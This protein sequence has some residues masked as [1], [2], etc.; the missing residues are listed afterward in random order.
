MTGPGS[1][2][3]PRTAL[4][5]V[6]PGTGVCLKCRETF[7]PG[8]GVDVA[9]ATRC[10]HRATAHPVVYRRPDEPHPEGQ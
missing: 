6:A 5:I 8:R 1:W 9:E 7:I 4:L 10:H 2:K 3:T